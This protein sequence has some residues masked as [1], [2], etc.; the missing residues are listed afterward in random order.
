M[1]PPLRNRKLDHIDLAMESRENGSVDPGWSSVRLSPVALPTLDPWDVDLTT[2]FLGHS[3]KVP[4]LIA[5]MTG[6]HE[7]TQR[8]NANLAIAADTC[9]VAMG[10][11][12]QRVALQDVSLSPSYAV[13]RDHAPNSFICGNIGISQLVEDPMAATEI[14]R[15]IDMV[16]ANAIAVHINVLQELVQPEGGIVLSSALS[17]LAD[18][19]ERCPVP[20]IVKETGCGLDG[21]TAHRLKDAGAAALDVG[22]AGGTSFVQIEGIRAGRNGDGHKARLAE[23]FANWGLPTVD[24]VREVRNAG[25]PVIATGGIRNGLD[26]A[27]ALALGSS[28]AGIGRQMLAAALKGPDEASE[29]LHAIIEELT[30]A[31]VLTDSRNVEVLRETGVSGE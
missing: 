3:L 10:V 29:E 12:S 4:I 8:I 13:V 28:L 21:K 19:I 27:K 20:V 26:V 17:A 6:G 9:G 22:G 1:T 31:M 18:F 14:T 5:G 16:E 2:D 30:I 15:L 23:T 7:D 25:L 11:G 24:S